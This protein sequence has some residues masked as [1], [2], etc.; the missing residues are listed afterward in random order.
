MSPQ[1]RILLK[2][3]YDG[4]GFSG[5]QIQ[6]HARSIQATLERALR[7]MSG[8]EIALVCSGRTDSGVHATAQYAHFDYDGRMTG[9][10]IIKALNRLLDHDIRVLEALD[11]PLT[12]HARYQAYERSYRY[13]LAKEIVPFQRLYMGYMINQRL[14]LNKLRELAQPLIGKH[15]Y[16][17]FAQLNPEIPNHICEVK[18]LEIDEQPTHWEFT[19]TADRFLHNM[20]RRIVGTLANTCTKDL[21]PE[22][23]E[24]ILS[25]AEPKQT[26]VV[27]APPGGLY[28]IDVKYPSHFF[29]PRG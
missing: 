10:Q 16:S 1:R 11:V 9:E 7:R 29:E 27:P 15:D 2:L 6:P 22:V 21:A 25:E 13:L 18:R 19:I 12:L 23:I 24:R 8:A 28:L 14:S 3:A 26:L 20:V 4:S 17:S 5:W